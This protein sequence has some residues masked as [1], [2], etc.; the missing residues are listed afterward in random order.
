[1]NRKGWHMD[2]RNR[3]IRT[4]LAWAIAASVGVPMTWATGTHVA[5]AQEAQDFVV[6][7]LPNDF[8]SKQSK[9]S[10]T[11][12]DMV[13]GGVEYNNDAAKSYLKD[14]ILTRLSQYNNPTNFNAARN[15]LSRLL[16]ESKNDKIKPESRKEFADAVVE[17]L[18]EAIGNPRFHP[19]S[20]LGCLNVLCQVDSKPAKNNEAAVPH[21][22]AFRVLG[23][24]LM[25]YEKEGRFADAFLIETLGGLDRHARAGASGWT[26]QQKSAIAKKLI[27]IMRGPLPAGREPQVHTYIQRR[28]IE[29]LTPLSDVPEYSD[30]KKFMIDQLKDRHADS[31]VRLHCVRHLGRP[32]MLK[33]MPAEEVQSLSTSVVH[34]LKSE[35]IKW[36]DSVKDPTQLGMGSGGMGGGGKG[37]GMGMGAEG[38][39]ETGSGSG[40]DSSDYGSGMQGGSEYGYGM[41]NQPKANNPLESQPPDVRIARRKL[42]ML[43]EYTRYG[44][45]GA[46]SVSKSKP[47][48]ELKGLLPALGQ[49]THASEL[50]RIID[51]VA[52]LHDTINGLAVVPVAPGKQP[53]PKNLI[54]ISGM[55]SL[56]SA[57][58]KPV[59]TILDAADEFPG[60]KEID[61]PAEETAAAAGD[62]KGAQ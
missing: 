25:N 18:T 16:D 19:A 40:S 54:T 37:M 29:V 57:V 56:R 15:E 48:T 22:G 36:E 11:I 55:G 38:G 24:L 35:L 14:Y 42:N 34:F 44:L 20:R 3:A 45:D 4:S 27:E 1:M 60:V 2:L 41:G 17:K 26:P 9:E 30:V 52:A 13:K 6:A 47:H 50:K 46:Y 32:V 62:Q 39:M 12:S 33:D 58:R 7:T 31:M 5:W 10:K 51:M 23:G 59:K 49:T 28:C 53:D 43:L 21:P 8:S 61:E